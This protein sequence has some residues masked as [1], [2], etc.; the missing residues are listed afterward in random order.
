MSTN[1]KQSRD[2]KPR[3]GHHGAAVSYFSRQP[4]TSQDARPVTWWRQSEAFILGALPW[5]LSYSQFYKSP[6]ATYFC[7]HPVRTLHV[8]S[9]YPHL[10]PLRNVQ[11][12][13]ILVQLLKLVF[14]VQGFSRNFLVACERTVLGHCSVVY[15]TP[16]NRIQF[17][18]LIHLSGEFTYND[19]KVPL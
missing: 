5:L 3:G 8:K 2:V 13:C 11:F 17:L 9:A 19:I 18:L 15:Y 16:G 1:H 4:I 14:W 12:C 7:C 6:S 10:W